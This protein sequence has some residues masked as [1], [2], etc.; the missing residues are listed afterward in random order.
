MAWDRRLS[1]SKMLFDHAKPPFPRP[2]FK[3]RGAV[4]ARQNILGA[5]PARGGRSRRKLGQGR[6]AAQ[7][8]NLPPIICDHRA[9]RR[10]INPQRGQ[11]R[12]RLRFPIKLRDQNPQGRAIQRPIFT[13]QSGQAMVSLPPNRGDTSIGPATNSFPSAKRTAGANHDAARVD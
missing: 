4:K 6:G 8:Q 13:Q 3:S 10:L 2:G 5:V 12:R 1:V 7:G 11:N 9:H